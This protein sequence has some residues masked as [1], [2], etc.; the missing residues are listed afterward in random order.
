MKKPVA[1]DVEVRAKTGT[2]NF[3]RG[4]SGIIHGRQGKKLAFAIFSADLPARAR[5]DNTV[6][7]PPGTK[8]FNKRAVGLEQA[9]LA[10]WIRRFAL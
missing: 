2:L 10:E 9:L 7:R 4:L 3:V 6:A 5:I 1:E 8:T